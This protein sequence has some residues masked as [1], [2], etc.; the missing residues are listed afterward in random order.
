[1]LSAFPHYNKYLKRKIS[2]SERLYFGSQFWRFWSVIDWHI[3]TGVN[4]RE[5][6]QLVAGS[7][8]EEGA[9]FHC[10]H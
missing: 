2:L 1:V 5:T 7:K 10:L 8:K 6:A 4:G 9:R 3:M